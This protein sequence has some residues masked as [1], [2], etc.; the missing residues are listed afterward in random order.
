MYIALY[1]KRNNPCQFELHMQKTKE[2]VPQEGGL[3]RWKALTGDSNG[4]ETFHCK[5]FWLSNHPHVLIGQ[6]SMQFKIKT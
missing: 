6:K 5:P 2:N 4:N 1:L 3:C